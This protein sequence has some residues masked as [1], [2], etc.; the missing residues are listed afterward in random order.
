MLAAKKTIAPTAIPI[1]SSNLITPIP[2][3]PR[4]RPD[5][6]D[7]QTVLTNQETIMGVYTVR[8]WC[9]PPNAEFRHCIVTIEAKDQPTTELGPVH[10]IDDLS[11]QDVT[12]EGNPD[13]ILGVGPVMGSVFPATIVYDLGDQPIEVLNTADNRCRTHFEDIDG[14]GSWEGIGCDSAL[15]YQFCSGLTT[16][17]A[18]AR[19]IYRYEAGRGYLPANLQFAEQYAQDIAFQTE[20]AQ[21]AMPGGFGEYDGTTKCGVLGLVLAYL[22]SGQIEEAWSALYH[23]YDYPDADEFASQIEEGVS[24]SALFAGSQASE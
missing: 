13:L 22:Y 12:G 7:D 1:K 17:Q 14:D 5:L 16:D 2:L 11:G 10:W 23:H 24:G 20:I 9:T 4:Y 8:H 21:N 19:V 3:L 15:A 18:N 6:I